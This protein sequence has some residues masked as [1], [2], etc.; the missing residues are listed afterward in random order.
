MTS[1]KECMAVKL[2][3]HEVGKYRSP[4][5]VQEPWSQ[6]I[7]TGKWMSQILFTMFYL[8]DVTYKSMDT[9]F[10]GT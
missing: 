10:I 3:S 2:K 7:Q 9:Y 4:S 6:V 5:A 1:E 8:R